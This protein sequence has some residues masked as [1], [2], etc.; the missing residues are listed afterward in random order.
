MLDAETSAPAWPK[1]YGRDLHPNTL[2]S[3]L[4]SHAATAASRDASSSPANESAT[5]DLIDTSYVRI[6]DE[7]LRERF[8]FFLN[9]IAEDLVE[10]QDRLNALDMHCGDGDCGDALAKIGRAI[11]DAI[12]QDQAAASSVNGNAPQQALLFGGFEYPHRVLMRC[13]LILEDG[14][15]SLCILLALFCSAAAKVS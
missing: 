12:A 2:S 13:S 10:C 15:G 4:V 7:R 5:A 3:M 6:G 9:T 11:C 1:S 8:R 14:G